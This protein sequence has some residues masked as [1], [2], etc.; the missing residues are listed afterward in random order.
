GKEGHEVIADVA[1]HY[2]NKT[3]SE[4][5]QQLLAVMHANNMAEVASFADEYRY[6]HPETGSWHYVD[7]PLKANNYVPSRDCPDKS[8]VIDIIYHFKQ[9]LNNNTLGDSTRAYALAFLIHFVGDLHQPLHASNNDDKGGN[10]VEV[11]FFGHHTNLHRVWDTNIISHEDTSAAD[12]AKTLLAKHKGVNIKPIE[13]GSIV[14]WALQTHKEAQKVAYGKLPKN[15][16]IGEAYI[17]AAQPVVDKQL[18]R[19]GVRLASVLNQILG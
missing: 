11:T 3:A 17:E 10:E 12:L 7:I 8:C 6:S 4:K 16:R 1:Q 14:D 2:L 19:A 5:V 15:R 13:K 9:I 18:Y